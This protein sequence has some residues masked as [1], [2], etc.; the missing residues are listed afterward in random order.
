MVCYGEI[1]RDSVALKYHRIYGTSIMAEPATA[2]I[3]LHIGGQEYREGWKIL[4][5][6]PGPIV[7]YVGNCNDL[8]FLEDGS[9]S[10]VYASHVFEHLAYDG[11]LLGSL[12]QVYRVLK[13]GGRLRA[14]VPDLD[15]LCR[16]FV[17]PAVN[18]EGKFHIMR[19]M[20]GGRK[21]P[22][23]VHFAGLDAQIFGS[24]LHEAGFRQ[25]ERVK[26]FGLFDDTSEM[27]FGHTPIS[28]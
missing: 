13:P 2:G 22:Y 6:I 5:A 25:I 7:D 18:P 3:K 20:F 19:M 12:R 15:T 21:T 8:S 4:D 1:R 11:E 14:A 26:S 16:L 28:L 27:L 10:E 24:F 9:C 17:H 23:D